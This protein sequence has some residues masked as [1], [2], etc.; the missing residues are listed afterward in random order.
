MQSKE[1]AAGFLVSGSASPKY[2]PQIFSPNILPKN[3]PQIFFPTIFVVVLN[4]LPSS[5]FARFPSQ[6]WR[7]KRVPTGVWQVCIFRKLHSKSL[8]FLVRDHYKKD[9]VWI[10]TCVDHTYVGWCLVLASGKLRVRILKW[11]AFDAYASFVNDVRIP[12]QD[13]RA[14]DAHFTRTRHL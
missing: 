9:C 7:H 12:A 13:S 1:E 10:V 8:N 4:F 3:F 2:F 14:L 5:F 6:H 11:R